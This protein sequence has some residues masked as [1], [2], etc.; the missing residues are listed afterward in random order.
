MMAADLNSSSR[1]ESNSSDSIKEDTSNNIV[2]LVSNSQLDK[3]ANNFRMRNTV[4]SEDEAAE[5][6][7]P[8][9]NVQPDLSDHYTRNSVLN[10]RSAIGQQMAT[11]SILERTADSFLLRTSM[12]HL[13]RSQISE[14]NEE[15]LV[16]QVVESDL[17]RSIS[18]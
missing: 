3:E 5:L 7:A 16:E 4:K 1:H 9:L 18:N 6:M 15:P 10:T 12:M 14:E 2:N 17:R 8:L 11:K 13:K